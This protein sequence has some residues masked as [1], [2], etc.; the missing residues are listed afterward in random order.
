[1]AP[2]LLL[3]LATLVAFAPHANDGPHEPRKRTVRSGSDGSP[4][5]AQVAA[6]AGAV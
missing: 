1:M 4:A 5:A 2:A 3:S 6:I